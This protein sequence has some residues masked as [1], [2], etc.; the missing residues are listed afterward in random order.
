MVTV[1]MCI[2]GKLLGFEVIRLMTWTLS[3][4]NLEKYKLNLHQLVEEKHLL[5]VMVSF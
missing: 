4:A 1:H 2:S 3:E 5:V